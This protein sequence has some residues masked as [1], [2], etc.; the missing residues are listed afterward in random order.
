MSC[1]SRIGWLYRDSL[2]REWEVAYAVLPPCDSVEPRW[3]LIPRGPFC[4]NPM[5]VDEF[6]L[7]ADF[8]R[9]TP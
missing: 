4:A 6:T 7:D 8:T 2:N 1:V 3:M 9:V 5:P